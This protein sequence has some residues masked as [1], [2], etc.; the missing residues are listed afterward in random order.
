VPNN[1]VE[2]E[3]AFHVLNKNSWTLGEL[4]EYEHFLNDIRSENDKI[5]TAKEEEKINIAK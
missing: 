1:L 5:D 4:N 3:E 2:L